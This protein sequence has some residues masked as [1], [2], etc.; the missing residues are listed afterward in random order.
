LKILIISY[1]FPP[2]GGG[3]GK[4]VYYTSREF[5]KMGHEVAVLTLRFQ[6]QLREE[7][8]DGIKVYRISALRKKLH[9]S[10]PPE[11]ATFSLSGIFCAGKIAEIFKPDLSMAYFTIPSGVIS[12][13]L[14]KTKR[15]PY[16]TLL[17]GQD[18]PGWLPEVLRG[19]H[20]FCMPMIKY[21]WNMS[22]KV[23][24]NSRG[25]AVMANKSAPNLEIIS[26]PNG[27]DTQ[28]Y[29]PFFDHYDRGK[30]VS[31]FFSGRLRFQKGLNYLIES[32]SQ[33]HDQKLKEEGNIPDFCLKIAGS[34]PKEG[35][36][37]MMVREKGLGDVVHFLGYLNEEELIEEY[38]RS[39]IFVNPSLNEGMPNS[40]LE[41]MAC[42][43]PCIVSNIEGNDELVID[44]KNGLLIKPK[45]ILDLAGSIEKLLVDTPLRRAMGSFGREFVMR[46]FTWQ[47][48]AEKLMAIIQ[49]H[50]VEE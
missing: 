32:I 4:A 44:G 23:I 24:A 2:V 9:Q 17:R 3:T 1:E 7:V 16:V 47:K 31:I 26:I 35:S 20:A 40:V 30:K 33:I 15:I 36:L 21:I 50:D 10:N 42:G 46:N 12:L 39:D 25:L 37:R 18:V 29:S 28:K 5:V 27:I 48:T 45:D 22:E 14:K 6:K 13:W 49:K 34:G 43:L 38:H 41:A 11:I 19:Y 8:I